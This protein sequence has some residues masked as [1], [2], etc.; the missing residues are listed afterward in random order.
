LVKDRAIAGRAGKDLQAF[1]AKF[2]AKG[3]PKKPIPNSPN[4]NFNFNV[5]L[6]PPIKMIACNQSIKSPY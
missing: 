5:L 6:L 1:V 4:F 3:K 2:P